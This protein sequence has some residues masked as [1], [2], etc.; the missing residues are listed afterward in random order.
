VTQTTARGWSLESE[1]DRTAGQ[2]LQLA[3]GLATAGLWLLFV[4]LP[5]L[6]LTLLLVVIAVLAY[7]WIARRVPPMSVRRP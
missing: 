1:V 3:Q 6:L 2:A 4:G 5:A 7:R